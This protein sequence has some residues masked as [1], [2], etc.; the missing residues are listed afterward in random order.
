[1]GAQLLEGHS[2][3]DKTAY[4]VAIAS[5]ATADHSASMNE[6][7]Y[8]MNLTDSAGLSDADKQKVAQAARDASGSQLRGALDQLKSGDLKF[9]LVADL[10]A[11]GEADSNLAP[12][13]KEHIAGIAKYLGVDSNQ[14]KNLNDYVKV[15]SGEPASLGIMDEANA[16]DERQGFLGGERGDVGQRLAGSGINLG[17]LTKGLMG[18]VGPMIL[19]SLF[20]RGGMQSDPRSSGISA[21]SGLGGMLGTSG[22]LGGLLGSS[23]LGGIL[24]NLTGGRGLSGSGLGGLLSGLFR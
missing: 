15:A 8:L 17:A 22:G 11:F 12:E 10:I 16:R 6:V 13:E 4:L 9:S 24:G 5:I 7:E 14:F 19:G 3:A 1:M 21:G 20:S 18:F 2:A 23:G